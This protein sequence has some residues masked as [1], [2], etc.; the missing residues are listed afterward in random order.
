MVQERAHR[1]QG[2]K[3]FAPDLMRG[4]HRIHRNQD[5]AVAVPRQDGRCHFMVESQALGNDVR[6]VIGAML[7]RGPREQ[8]AHQ[9]PIIGLQVQCH[10]RGH[11]KFAAY[12]IGRPGL[13][14]VARDSIQDKPASGRL[15]GGHLLPHHVEYDLVGHE[16]A[17]VKILLDGQ[18]ERGAP[19]HVIAQQFTGRDVGDVEVRG[20]QRALVPLPAP[21]GAII[22]TRMLIP[23]HV[24]IPRAGRPVAE[25]IC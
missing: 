1:F 13:V 25:G 20:D 12:L 6:G 18:A 16:L 22:S 2:G 14:H 9:F 24:I 7:Q 23:F 21:G 17:A 15:R 19:R 10:I 3:D 8:P 5:S 4:T 11:P